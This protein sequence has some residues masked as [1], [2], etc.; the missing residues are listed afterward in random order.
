MENG[1]LE[2]GVHVHQ[3]KPPALA[4]D[5]FVTLTENYCY[6]KLSEFTLPPP[7]IYW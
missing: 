3:E 6:P 1:N 5:N 7:I 4:R 2:V